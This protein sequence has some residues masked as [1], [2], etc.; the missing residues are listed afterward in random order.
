MDIVGWKRWDFIY[1]LL[2]LGTFDYDARSLVKNSILASGPSAV[3]K[4]ADMHGY[5]FY[6]KLLK[7]V[8]LPLDVVYTPD[9]TD[10][11]FIPDSSG[12]SDVEDDYNQYDDD[13][14]EDEDEEDEDEEDEDEEPRKKSRV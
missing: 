14:D 2:I 8:M 3:K 9:P 11:D 4:Y 1:F 7:M 5:L 6:D 12:W 10:F 13:Y